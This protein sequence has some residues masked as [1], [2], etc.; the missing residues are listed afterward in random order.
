MEIIIGGL[1]GL[2]NLIMLFELN[3]I[4]R[5][6]EKISG[7]S[8]RVTRLETEVESCPSCRDALGR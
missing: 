7:L 3:R 6:L 2:L 8:E 1:V 5:E 4:S